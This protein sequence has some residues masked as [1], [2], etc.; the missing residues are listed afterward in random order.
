MSIT[1]H[2]VLILKTVAISTSCRCGLRKRLGEHCDK[3]NT[4]VAIVIDYYDTDII[5]GD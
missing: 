4:D 1:E 5:G 3:C 2:I